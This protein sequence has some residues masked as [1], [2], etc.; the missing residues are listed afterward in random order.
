[1]VEADGSVSGVAAG[2]GLALALRTWPG[3]ARHDF[4]G[5]WLVRAKRPWLWLVFAV[6][7][8]GIAYATLGPEAWQIRL[9]LPYQQVS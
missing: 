6:L 4:G 8:A 2:I 7:L 5:L 1:M 3:H 9:G